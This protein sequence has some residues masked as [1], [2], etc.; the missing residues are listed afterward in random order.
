MFPIKTDKRTP[1]RKK[2]ER[3]LMLE[4]YGINGLINLRAGLK[5]NGDIVPEVE[6][7]DWDEFYK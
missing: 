3:K 2:F 7:I 4:L 6:L 1:E 5:P